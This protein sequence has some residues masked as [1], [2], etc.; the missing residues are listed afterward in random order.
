V[1]EYTRQVNETRSDRKRKSVNVHR[2]DQRVQLPF[3]G[4]LVRPVGRFLDGG[5]RS[6][7]AI[8]AADPATEVRANDAIN[9]YA[10]VR[11]GAYTHVGP[12]TRESLTVARGCVY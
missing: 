12:T 7:D 3:R 9:S 4:R 6:G 10:R 2:S 11:D 5:G 1:T 8:P